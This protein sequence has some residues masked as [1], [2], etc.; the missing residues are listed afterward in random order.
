[1]VR[2]WSN[3][4]SGDAARLWSDGGI[5]IAVRNGWRACWEK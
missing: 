3:D 5:R 2:P 1:M 4:I